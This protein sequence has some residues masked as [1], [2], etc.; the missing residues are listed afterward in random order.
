MC[1]VYIFMAVLVRVMK[2]YI[3]NVI[4]R[5]PQQNAPMFIVLTSFIL[6]EIEWGFRKKSLQKVPHMVHQGLLAPQGL[7][8]PCAVVQN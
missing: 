7:Y 6:N 1:Q 3:G 4:K 2:I 5:P 8:E